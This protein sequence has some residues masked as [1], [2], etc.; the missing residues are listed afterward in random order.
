MVKITRFKGIT[1]FWKNLPLFGKFMLGFS[2]PAL[3]MLYTGFTVAHEF[4]KLEENLKAGDQNNNKSLDYLK[5]MQYNLERGSQS[6][7]FYLLSKEEIHKNNYINSIYQLNNYSRKLITDLQPEYIEKYKFNTVAEQIKK[8]T[9]YKQQFLNL[10][11]SDADNYPA[12]FYASENV[13]PMMRDITQLIELMVLSEET[14]DAGEER[15]KLLASINSLRVTWHKMLGELRSYLAFRTP[16]AV[17]NIGYYREKIQTN[18]LEITEVEDLLTLEQLDAIEQIIPL[19]DNYN[20]NV[21]H[22]IGLHSSDKWR[23]DAYI[24]RHSYGPQLTSVKELLQQHIATQTRL[25]KNIANDINTAFADNIK[26]SIIFIFATVIA[27]V[28]IVWMLFR[29]MSKSLKNVIHVAGRIADEHFDNKFDSISKDEIGQVMSSLKRMQT[30]LLMSFEKLNKQ[31]IESSRV[32]TALSVSSTCALITDANNNIIFANEALKDLFSNIENELAQHINN[33]NANKLIG[34]NIELLL[35]TPYCREHP[36]SEL[37]QSYSTTLHIGSQHLHIIVTPV[38]ASNNTERTE[39][40]G[41]V[42]EWENCTEIFNS[43]DELKEIVKAASEGDFEQRIIEQGKSGFYLLAAQSIN[44]ML[45]TTGSGIKDVVRVMRALAG[46]DLTQK[47]SADYHG[48]LAQLKDDVNTTVERLTDVISV[49]HTNS[50]SSAKTA[51]EVSLTATEM[52]NGA[53]QQMSS[54]QQITS[55]MEQ[56]SANIRQSADNANATQN[57]AQQAANDA[58]ESGRTVLDAVKAMKDIADKILVVEEIARQTNLLAL[59][60]AIEAAR[61]GEHGKG[62]A[63]VASEVRKLAER[64]Q[65]SAA[66]IGQLSVT[67]MKV[68]EQ[69]SDKLKSLVPDIQKTAELV[70]EISVSAK[71]QD[72]GANEINQSLQQLD[73]VVSRS[74]ASASELSKSASELSQHAEQQRKA[75]RFFTLSVATT[76]QQNHRAADSPVHNERRDHKSVGA[77]LRTDKKFSNTSNDENGDELVRY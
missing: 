4:N 20:T 74:A 22:L 14:E 59:N 7:G 37:K 41:T 77:V 6:L 13:N 43:E 64:S 54:L 30:G 39:H 12:M 32:V 51:S 46:G 31:S 16:A 8:I 53:G 47:V 63:V 60:A 42:I 10:A 45:E 50:D 2:L 27:L 21:D 15:K 61:A 70:Q 34:E 65:K 33:F 25:Q 19:I 76:A 24:I 5:N 11:L 23:T 55:A 3:F 44:K 49:V 72:T 57:I 17:Q 62:F 38:F 18:I 9:D 48:I 28:L 52:G 66:E 36:L 56:M 73:S 35:N 40:L 75:M 29:Y 1:G 71:E 26:T 67:T 58:D 68:A 69:A